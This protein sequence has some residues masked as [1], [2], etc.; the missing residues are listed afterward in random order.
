MLGH[1]ARELG[2]VPRVAEARDPA[3]RQE[4]RLDRAARLLLLPGVR[5]LRPALRRSGPHVDV[6][7]FSRSRRH[8]LHEPLHALLALLAPGLDPEDARDLRVLD[9]VDEERL[10]IERVAAV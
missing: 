5:G 4:E 1:L 10:E 6:E 7:R 9:L 2:P 8:E 3:P